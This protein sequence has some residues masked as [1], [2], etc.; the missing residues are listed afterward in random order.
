MATTVNL[1]DRIQRFEKLRG[2]VN[3]MAAFE[4]WL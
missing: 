2:M 4:F 3:K 1:E